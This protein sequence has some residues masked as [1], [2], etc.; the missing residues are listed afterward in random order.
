MV[1]L[2]ESASVPLVFVQLQLPPEIGIAPAAGRNPDS[3]SEIGFHRG[4]PPHQAAGRG[5]RTF[6]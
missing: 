2:P 3:G 1:A 4:V 5:E 6:R